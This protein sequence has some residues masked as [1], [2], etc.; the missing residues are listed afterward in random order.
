M[1][2]SPVLS[3]RS[4]IGRKSLGDKLRFN[5][6]IY[7]LHL[8]LQEGQRLT[9]GKLGRASFPKGFYVY[10]GSAQKNL[11]QRIERHL[12]NAETPGGARWEWP[13]PPHWHIDY[14]LPHAKI[15]SIHVF[16]ASKEWECRLS[17]KLAGLEGAGVLMKGLGA[18]DC[19]CPSHLYYFPLRPHISG[20]GVLQYAPTG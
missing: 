10:V 7:F 6:G 9:V 8:S 1:T 17:R 20:R 19:K 12:R 5:S 15:L 18:S 3:Q 11:S 2:T 4:Q 16:K 14:L 13:S